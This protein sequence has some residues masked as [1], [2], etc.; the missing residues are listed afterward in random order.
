MYEY[1]Q[2]ETEPKQEKVQSN[3]LGRFNGA[4]E[5]VNKNK[6]P[7]LVEELKNGEPEVEEIETEVKE[8]PPEEENEKQLEI[9]HTEETTQEDVDKDF[10]EAL[11]E[12]QALSQNKLEGFKVPKNWKEWTPKQ[13]ADSIKAFLEGEKKKEKE[14]P[15]EKKEAMAD[16]DVV[17]EAEAI[18]QRPLPGFRAPAG[19]EDMSFDEKS[20]IVKNYEDTK[21]V[22]DHRTSVNEDNSETNNFES[23]KRYPTGLKVAEDVGHGIGKAVDMADAA[24]KKELGGSSIS[25]AVERA[26]EDIPHY[27]YTA[28]FG[29]R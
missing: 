17:K 28:L 10:Q 22:E 23:Y 14:A 8:L 16:E 25:G 1:V 19:W 15:L 4:L 29:R 13:K 24:A 20:K 3:G 7:S 2:N 6:K 26:K 27:D 11:E 18:A 12:A 9:E 21:K 5:W